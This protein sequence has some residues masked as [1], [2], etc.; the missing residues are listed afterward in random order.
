MKVSDV[1]TQE[2][3][4]VGVTQAE[5]SRA[6]GV[7]RPLVSSYEH[8]RN[9]PSVDQMTRLLSPLGLELRVQPLMTREDRRS[10]GFALRVVTHLRGDPEGT[11][12]RARAQLVRQRD[13]TTDNELP[14]LDVWESIL[15]LPVGVVCGVI[16]D[17]GEFARDLRQSSPLTVVLNDDER[18]EVIRE[19][20]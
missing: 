5:L 9:S 4:R 19:T 3:A 12:R 16:S 2:R 6:T 13:R 7:S 11:L 15:S 1:L 8:D 17:E 18:L 10:L 20:K 14:W